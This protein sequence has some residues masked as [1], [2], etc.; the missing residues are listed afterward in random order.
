MRFVRNDD[1]E[2]RSAANRRGKRREDGAQFAI[3]RSCDTRAEKR[4]EAFGYI[5]LFA[6]SSL[7]PLVILCALLRCKCHVNFAILTDSPRVRARQVVSVPLSRRNVDMP[8]ISNRT[9][10]TARQESLADPG[11]E[12]GIPEIDSR[13][14]G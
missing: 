10:Q 14:R 12:R 11:G 13:V 6:S 8:R 9:E 5:L 4:R 1:E 7:V 3:R 2:T